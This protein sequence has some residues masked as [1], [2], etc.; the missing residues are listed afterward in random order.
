MSRSSITLSS[1]LELCNRGANKPIQLLKVPETLTIATL[2][3]RLS[4]IASDILVLYITC[5]ETTRLWDLRNVTVSSNRITLASL[6]FINGKAD[7][8]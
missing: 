1:G 2:L 6:L 7:N 5:R 4:L 8:F 3:V